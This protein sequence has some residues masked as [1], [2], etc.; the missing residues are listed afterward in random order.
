[1]SKMWKSPIEIDMEWIEKDIIKQQDGW[2]L[3]RI[4][5]I[6]DVKVDKNELIKVLKYDRNQYERG[7]ADGKA[8]A[9]KHGQWL[10]LDNA[11]WGM[12]YCTC[13]VCGKRMIAE[14]LNFCGECGA[15]MDQ[16]KE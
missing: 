8:D 15:K 5:E 9:I 3:S 1:M 13:S 4:E 2:I 7:Y 10:D 14:R 16:V 6:I 11:P 12:F